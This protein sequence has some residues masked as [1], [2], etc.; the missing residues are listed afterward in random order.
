MTFEGRVK[1]AYCGYTDTINSTDTSI[2]IGCIRTSSLKRDVFFVRSIVK[3]K[4]RQFTW[5]QCLA[6]SVS[7][8]NF[9]VHR[10]ISETGDQDKTILITSRTEGSVYGCTIL[11]TADRYNSTSVLKT[12]QQNYGVLVQN[13]RIHPG[14]ATSQ[15]LT[16]GS[17]QEYLAVRTNA[18]NR[19]LCLWFVFV[20]L[21][22]VYLLQYGNP[23]QSKLEENIS[24]GGY[25]HFL[26]NYFNKYFKWSLNYEKMLCKHDVTD[27]FHSK[28][29][30][31]NLESKD[32]LAQI[33][34][35]SNII[36]P[37][38]HDVIVAPVTK[39]DNYF[40]S[41]TGQN[42]SSMD[43][44]LSIEFLRIETFRTF[45]KVAPVS[46]IRLAEA[47]FF[48]TKESDKVECF[49]CHV[50]HSGWRSGDIPSEIH[51]TLS[52]NC[53]FVRG[54]KTEN[55][56]LLPS[57]DPFTK[58]AKSPT[59]PMGQQPSLEDAEGCNDPLDLSTLNVGSGVC[60]LLGTQ[61]ANSSNR[62]RIM[63][64]TT[65]SGRDQESRHDSKL[66]SLDDALYSKQHIYSPGHGI[67]PEC[68]QTYHTVPYL[69]R[70]TGACAKLKLRPLGSVN[71]S[72]KYPAC[73]VLTVRMSSFKGWSSTSGHTTRSLADAGFMYTGEPFA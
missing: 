13:Q 44:S 25:K 6:K 3:V 33:S 48:Y 45:P 39:L 67:M 20:K 46:T 61:T 59:V 60:A 12:I 63:S 32:T 38:A 10:R 23:T 29:K 55:I 58:Q 47:G 72:V 64:G 41:F 1:P 40:Q 36:S 15:M 26:L 42:S 28:Q 70:T 18:V 5:T 56:P 43:V 14:H 35:W 51:K 69:H 21:L 37:Q 17:L 30:C 31:L 65:E 4:P 68:R 49:H 54:L 34:S 52:P 11:Y 2:Y 7:L 71:R 24:K 27:S 73:A 50:K 8:S 62:N 66:S 16:A 22:L 19:S 9:S 53:H 57:S